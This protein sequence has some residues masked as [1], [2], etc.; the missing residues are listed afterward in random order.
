MGQ[1]KEQIAQGLHLAS[2]DVGG[3]ILGGIIQGIFQLFGFRV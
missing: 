1:Y 2:W 3:D